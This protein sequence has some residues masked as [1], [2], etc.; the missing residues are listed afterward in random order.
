MSTL[1]ITS[2]IGKVLKK[3]QPLIHNQLNE[4]TVRK[5][6]TYC[7]VYTL[8]KYPVGQLSREA[9][10]TNKKNRSVFFSTGR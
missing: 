8:V 1:K 10:Q 4:T 6:K 9:K 7:Y 5:V 2:M 3:Y